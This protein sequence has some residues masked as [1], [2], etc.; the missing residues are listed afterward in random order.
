MVPQ[1]KF[2]GES[3]WYNWN[4]ENWGTKWP[5]SSVCVDDSDIDT[6][7][8]GFSSAWAPP[9]AAF[10]TW[11]RNQENVTFQLDYFE[12]GC[13]FVKYAPSPNKACP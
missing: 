7:S 2:E 4:V 9:V 6:I 3:D 10:E 5:I 1:P 12:P 11:A 8:F 13:G